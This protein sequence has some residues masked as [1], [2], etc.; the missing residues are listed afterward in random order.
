VVGVQAA[1]MV[2]GLGADVTILERSDARLRAL[3]DRF[4][5]SN[6]AP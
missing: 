6:I 2:R 1:R 4:E 5:G 3:D